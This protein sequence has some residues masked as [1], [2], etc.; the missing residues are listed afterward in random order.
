VRAH[1]EAP[2]LAGDAGSGALSQLDGAGT[3]ESAFFLLEPI[4]AQ[5]A[6]FESVGALM[7]RSLEGLL[8][9][10]VRVSAAPPTLDVPHP[11]LPNMGELTERVEALADALEE[12]QREGADAGGNAV[13]SASAEKVRL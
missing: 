1:D 4:E 5:L 12:Q 13:Q 9:Q 10:V 6:R 2:G 7:L 8:T 3:M 11:F